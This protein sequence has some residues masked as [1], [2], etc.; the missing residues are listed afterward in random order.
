MFPIDYLR[1]SRKNEVIIALKSGEFYK[2]F[3]EECDNFMNIYM[4]S[5]TVQTNQDND[6]SVEKAMIRGQSVKYIMMPNNVA[7]IVKDRRR[8]PRNSSNNSN[9]IHTNNNNN[10]YSNGQRGRGGYGQRGGRG[11]GYRGNYHNNGSRGGRQKYYKN[12]ETQ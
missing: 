8:T 3:L 7:D 10:S 6:V 11:N 4:S 5:V 2:G 9:I 1:A 12:N